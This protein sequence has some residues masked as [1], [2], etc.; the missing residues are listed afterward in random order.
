MQKRTRE[1]LAL[2]LLGVLLLVGVGVM[3]YYILVGHNWN[4]TASNIDDSIGKMD[5]YT[6]FLYEGTRPSPAEAERIS[7]AQPLLDEQSRGISKETRESNGGGDPIDIADA[8]KSY[9]EKGATVFMLDVANMARY[10][11]PYVVGKNGKRVGLMSAMAP[12]RKTEMRRAVIGLDRQE[13]DC[14]VALTDDAEVC[15]PI[16]GG[17][18]IIV[19]DDPDEESPRDEYRGSSYCVGVP[20]VGE[21]QAVLMSPSG[22]LSSKTITEL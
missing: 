19:C 7:D 15:K 9:Q 16:V 14:I 6:V 22:V 4:V 2:V 17:I 11:E 10:S 1:I 20:Y 5:G 18:S 12:V 13:A 3:G 21:I 8:V